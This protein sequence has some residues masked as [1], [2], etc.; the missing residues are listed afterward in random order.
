MP[1]TKR[2]IYFDA[3]CFIDLAS[4]ATG[5]FVEADRAEHAYWCRKFLDASRDGVVQVYTSAFSIV[6]CIGVRDFDRKLIMSDNVQ[7]LFNGMLLSGS[8]GVLPIQPTPLIFRDARD[9]V[10]KHKTSIRGADA[11]HVASALSVG[12]QDFITTDVKTIGK[13]ANITK[14]KKLGMSV[15]D[16]SEIKSILPDEYR[17]NGLINDPAE[18]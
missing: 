5:N 17:Q 11:L 16:A 7:R 4:H 13:A 9:L 14:L 12:C 10:W 1:A 6:E 8:S 18:N 2:N 3:C 15:S